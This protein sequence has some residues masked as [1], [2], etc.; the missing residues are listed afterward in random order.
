MLLKVEDVPSQ[1]SSRTF[2]RLQCTLRREED[3]EDPQSQ[4]TSHVEVSSYVALSVHREPSHVGYRSSK[5]PRKATENVSPSSLN[6]FLEG[7]RTLVRKG[8]EET[9]KMMKTEK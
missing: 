1:S 9:G 6:S 5:E 7:A 3:F 8:G 2:Q 4:E